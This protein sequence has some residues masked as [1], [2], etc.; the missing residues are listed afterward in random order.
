MVAHRRERGYGYKRPFGPQGSGDVYEAAGGK[1]ALP[2]AGV[3]RLSTAIRVARPR[4]RRETNTVELDGPL[5]AEDLLEHPWRALD[6]RR[7]A[8]CAAEHG[9]VVQRPAYL[10]IGM[11]AL[12]NKDQLILNEKDLVTLESG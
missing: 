9:R 8:A 7:E 6:V 12:E 3:W 5:P 1:P 11:K 4:K 2:G 10:G